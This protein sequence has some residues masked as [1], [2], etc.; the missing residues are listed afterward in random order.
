MTPE[1]RRVLVVDDEVD[2]RELIV[3]LLAGAGYAVE[4]ASNGVE[5]LEKVQ[6]ERPDLIVLDIMMPVLDGW[7]VLERLR[8]I[9]APPAVVIL[10][11]A[12]DEV[13]AVR[14]GAWECLEK[15]LVA[16]TLIEACR[17]A[18]AAA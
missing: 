4:V 2:I 9:P 3:L 7:G 10:T 6:K 14:A 12:P 11:A 5:A 16:S 15:P 1:R 13:R 8:G 18:L 17:R